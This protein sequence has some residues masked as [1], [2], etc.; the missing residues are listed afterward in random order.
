MKSQLTFLRVLGWGILLG[1]I[2]F[3]GCNGDG[4]GVT[5]SGEPD[6]AYMCADTATGW[7]GSD[8]THKLC[9]DTTLHRTTEK[10]PVVSNGD[11]CEDPSTATPDCFEGRPCVAYTEIFVKINM[12]STCFSCHPTEGGDLT[13]RHNKPSYPV[14]LG[15]DTTGAIPFKA[16]ANPDTKIKKRVEP[17]FPEFSLL[18]DVLDSPDGSADYDIVRM[19]DQS[20]ATPEFIQTIYDWIY[21]GAK[22]ECP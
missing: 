19:P 7:V 10:P 21:G 5:A 18:Y 15:P 6:L 2:F 3:L 22:Y 14:L 16:P 13:F 4:I 1:C 8:P 20:E 11:P 12:Y 17:Y 9:T